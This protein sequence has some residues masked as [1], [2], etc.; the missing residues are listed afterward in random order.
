MCAIAGSAGC[1]L[2][3]FPTFCAQLTS[4]VGNREAVAAATW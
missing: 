3:S 1:E 2:K 4:N